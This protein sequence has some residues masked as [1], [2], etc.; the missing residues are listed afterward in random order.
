[1]QSPTYFQLEGALKI[2][3]FSLR[4]AVNAPQLTKQWC[5]VQANRSSCSFI[6]TEALSVSLFPE[7]TVLLEKLAFSKEPVL[8]ANSALKLEL[9][10][11]HLLI[12][13]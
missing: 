7:K 3:Y 11:N 4:H 8:F 12:M 6:N 9:Q 10:E 1:M 5:K 2:Q 13:W